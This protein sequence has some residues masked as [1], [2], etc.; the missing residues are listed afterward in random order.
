MWYLIVSI[1]DL[2]TI[3]YFYHHTVVVSAKYEGLISFGFSSSLSHILNQN[4][5]WNLQIMTKKMFHADVSLKEQLM[6]FV[7]YSFLKVSTCL[8]EFSFQKG[9]LN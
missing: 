6:S 4:L 2:C 1:P 9:V 7:F 3:T 5:I 8:Y